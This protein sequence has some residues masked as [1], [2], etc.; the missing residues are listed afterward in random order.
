[1]SDEKLLTRRTA[2]KMGV[3]GVGAITAAGCNC[4]SNKETACGCGPKPTGIPAMKTEDFYTNGAFDS[5]KALD[6]D[7]FPLEDFFV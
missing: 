5:K 2:L 4:K 7:I 6:V 3:C 1:M